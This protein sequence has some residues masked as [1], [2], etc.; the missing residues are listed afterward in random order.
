MVCGQ[1]WPHT[2]AKRGGVIMEKIIKIVRVEIN[3]CVHYGF[4][5]ND[6][7]ELA[8]GSLES[9]KKSGHI[10][11]LSDCKI[12]PP[13]GFGKQIIVASNYTEN[14]IPD[15]TV[16]RKP[17]VYVLKPSTSVIGT[18]EDVIYPKNCSHVNYETE[19]GVVI[20][21]KAKNVSKEDALNYVLGY[22]LIN[23]ITDRDRLD[24]TWTFGKGRDT[25]LPVGPCIWVRCSDEGLYAEGYLNGEFVQRVDTAHL[26]HS[27][28]EIIEELSN[29][30]TLLPG[31]LICSGTSHGGGSIKPGDTF[32]VKHEI[33]GELRNNIVA[34]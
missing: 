18:G 24:G 19:V 14:K 30:M 34:E 20:G 32:V 21:R 9:L 17:A 33:I 11:K 31:D 15:R 1:L 28:S 13:V 29:Y 3:D 26:T 27:I 10:V 2:I 22:T 12:L 25:F 8:S 16:E 7:V 6:M 23:D 4:L 5:N